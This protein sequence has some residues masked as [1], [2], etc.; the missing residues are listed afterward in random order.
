MLEQVSM[1]VV[2]GVIGSLLSKLGGLLKEE[3]NLQKSVRGE[4]MFLKAEFERM[5]AA[6]LMVSEAP[7]DQQPSILV[8]LWARDVR[9]LSYD[10]EDKVDTFMVRIDRAPKELHGLRGFIDRSLDLLTKAK[11]RHKL[12]T[13]IKDLRSSIEEVSERRDRYMVTQVA[14]PAD[15]PVQNLRLSAMYKKVDELIGTEE[16]CDEFIGRLIEEKDEPSKKQLKTAIVGFGGLGKTTLAKVAYDKLKEQFDC[17]AFICVSL[18]PN[19]ERIFVKMLRQLMKDDKY[20]ATCDTA[21]LINDVRAFLQNKRYLIVIDDIWKA[22]VWK[23]IQYALTENECGSIIISTTRN[24]DVAKKIGGVYHLQP[25]SLADSRKLFNLRIFGTEDKCLSN[26]LAEVST[27]ILRKCG[28][29][30]LAIITIASTLANKK[31]MENIYQYWSKVCKTLGSGLEDS[32]DVEDMRRI[33][34]ISYYDL[35]L[36]LKNCML[37]LGSYPEDYEISTKDLIWKWMGEGFI[38]KEQGRSFYEVGKDYIDELINRSMIQ[39]S[40]THPDSKKAVECRVHDMV[41]DLITRLANEDGFMATIHYHQPRCQQERIHRLSL[42]TSNEEDVKQLSAANLCHQ[43]DNRCFKEI[44][45]LIHLRYLGLRYA[46][47]AE[48]PK[49]IQKLQLLQMLDI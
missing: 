3:Y 43:V 12:G 21:Q 39:P 37:Y 45:N 5:Q 26:E 38:L 19:I 2:T 20:E 42:Q 35:P 40:R 34:S 48:I 1:E 24:L 9:E 31:G 49:E 25:L 30:P 27:E 13:Q 32:P 23:I 11:I 36:H 46:G 47:I 14:K 22:S 7:M 8:K 15:V 17:A 33:L 16:K 4:I 18:N 10:V 44:C 6:L 29:L 41:L 28:G